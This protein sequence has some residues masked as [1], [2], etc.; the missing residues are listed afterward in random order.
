MLKKLEADLTEVEFSQALKSMP[1]GKAPGPDGLTTLYY[2][3][4]QDH[5]TS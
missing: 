4:F 1:L 2:K 3:K 5:L